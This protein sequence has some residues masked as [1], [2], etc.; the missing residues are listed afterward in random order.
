MILNKDGVD[1]AIV[2]D[3]SSAASRYLAFFR[4]KDEAVLQSVLKECTEKQ[5]TKA[6]PVRTKPSILAELKRLKSLIPDMA[7]KLLE[8]KKELTR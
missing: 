3:K 6:K 5:L 7:K 2:K 4:A 8:K 1:F